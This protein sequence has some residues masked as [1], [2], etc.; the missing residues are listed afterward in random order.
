MAR[1]IKL[2]KRL[3]IFGFIFI[4]LFYVLVSF[5][6][7]SS[8]S[9]IQIT[10]IQK[11]TIVYGYQ[12][13]NQAT[14]F[15]AANFNLLIVDFEKSRTDFYIPYAQWMTDLR[16][17]SSSI[18]IF[19]YKNIH[20]MNTY[21]DDWS[22]V[23]SHENWFV[24]DVNGNRIINPSWG[25]YLMDVGNIGWREHWVSYVNNKLAISPEYTGVFADD[26]SD[27]IN[28][29]IFTQTLTS[30][31]INGWH[32]A[33]LGMLMYIQANLSSDKQLIINTE[34]GWS[35][36]H[37]NSDY[38]EFADGMLIEGYFHAP[39]ED[40]TSYTKVLPSQIDCLISGSSAG[41]LMIAVSGSTT[42]DS[43]ILKWT[44]ASFLLGVNSSNSYWCWNIGSSY[45]ID[46]EYHSITE[47]NLGSPIGPYYTTQNIYMRDFTGGK[48]L[49]NPSE[50]PV[51]IYLAD[52]FWLLNNTKIFALTLSGYSGEI[53]LNA[54]VPSP[55]V[56]PS[57][58]TT[59]TPIP[60]ITPMPTLTPIP[61]ITPMPTLTPI[62]TITPMP[63]LTPIPTPIPTTTPSFASPSVMPSSSSSPTFSS[64][65]NP[66]SSAIPDYQI[67]LIVILPLSALVSLVLI[68]R[69]KIPWISRKYINCPSKFFYTRLS[70]IN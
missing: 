25:T 57:P 62:P 48:V 33:T 28:Q 20:Y 56:S 27:E 41:K 67:A 8:P 38:L 53:L 39:W 47:T 18:L 43:R 49:S 68:K 19:G 44:Y 2:L 34:A 11:A 14:T 21:Y 10:P 26:V 63:T 46:P 9:Q 32:S 54:P 52:N 45:A 40:S 4:F 24:H 66:K 59:L 29:E 35:P 13:N 17:K 42:E 5:Q 70:I 65:E 12:W 15:V 30:E 7:F 16:S 3:L 36:N 50:N 51:T 60:T 23:N 55:I 64:S 6:D 58:T 22:E 37:L 69:K 31:T 61:T 1:G